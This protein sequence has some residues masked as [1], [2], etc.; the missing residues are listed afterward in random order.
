[1]PVRLAVPTFRLMAHRT[2]RA[3]E[4]PCRSDLRQE[5]PFDRG[6]RAVVAPVEDPLLDPLAAHQTG[7]GQD[8]HVL[9]QRG[10]ADAE[11]AGNEEPADAIVLQVAVDLRGKV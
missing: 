1:M 3:A 7:V 11:L 5:L 10:L 6:D 8:P 4:R 9:A 2:G